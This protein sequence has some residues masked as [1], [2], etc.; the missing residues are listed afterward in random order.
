[1]FCLELNTGFVN[2]SVEVHLYSTTFTP[3][4]EQRCSSDANGKKW[5]E[6]DPEIEGGREGEIDKIIDS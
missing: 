1:M 2:V 5:R 4:F 3:Y 6:K